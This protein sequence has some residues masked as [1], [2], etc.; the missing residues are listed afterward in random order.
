MSS[1]IINNDYSFLKTDNQKVT[2]FLFKNLR[3]R[4]KNYFHDRRYRMKLW[5]GYINFFNNETGKFLTGLLPEVLATLNH[6]KVE[7]KTE[8]NRKILNFGI[9]KIDKNFLL[10][11]K[12]ANKP[13]IELFDY[14]V[15]YVNQVIK[16]KRGIIF[17]PTSSGKSLVMVCIIKALLA[18]TTVL[19]LQDSLDLAKQNY[20]ELCGWGIPN[21]G[22]LWGGA[23]KPDFITVASI[24][25]IHKIEK[26]LP[27]IDV[28]IVDE[29]HDLMSKVPINTYKK[30][31]NTSI[32]V[33]VSATPFKDGGKD[34]VQ[35]HQVKGF[36]GPVLKT[37]ATEKGI[38]TTKELQDRDILAKSN[39]TFY[40]IDYPALPYETFQ[41]SVTKGIAENFYFHQIINDLAKKKKGRTLILVE[42]ISQGDSISGLIPN[43]LWIRGQDNA[44]TRKEVIKELSY[45]KGDVIAIATRHIFNTGI[46]V[47]LHNLINAAGGFGEH[48]I[49]QRMGRGLRVAEDKNGLNYE[50]FL[51]KNNPYLEKHSKKRISVLKKE[52]HIV[53]IKESI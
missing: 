40:V 48:M 37:K 3:F 4:K 14:Q 29:I 19:L 25:S 2:D 23:N 41:D 21:V 38:L 42:R 34:L 45:S 1:L 6:Y 8:D 33:A 46:N 11:N 32:R 5:D 9:Q 39:C 10:N 52:G 44:K 15:D 31:K 50:D 27:K 47:F 17:S 26:V 43:S 35:K 18:K 30:L 28:L 7:Y 53:S 24:S 20:D 49:I 22:T 16:H 36:F 12:P 13:E 51:F